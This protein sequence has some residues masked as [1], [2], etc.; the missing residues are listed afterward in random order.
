LWETA[1]ATCD[2]WNAPDIVPAITYSDLL[3]AIE[4]FER[5]FGVR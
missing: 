1:M 4:W 2:L 5:V 3:R